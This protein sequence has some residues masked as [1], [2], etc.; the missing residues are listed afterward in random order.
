MTKCEK[1]LDQAL[2]YCQLFNL[3]APRA[4]TFETYGNLYRERGDAARAT[5]FYERA[6]RAYDEAGID[7]TR[8][9]LLDEQ[10]LLNLQLGNLTMA[11]SLL[12]RLVDARLEAKDE[13]GSH[14]AMLSR[15]RVMLAQ[16]DYEAARADLQ[17]ALEYFRE[18]GL[19]YYEAQASVALAA[20]DFV[21]GE[22]SSNLSHLRRT[23]DLA[24]RYDYEY[25]LQRQVADNPPL[26]AQAEVVELLPPDVREQL[27]SGAGRLEQRVSIIAE[28]APVTMP[29]PQHV[30]DL[31]LNMLGPVEIFRDPARPMAADAWTTKRAR[32]IL[33]FIA[34]RRHRRA[35]KDTII[36]T[37]WG[38][39]DFEAVEKNF[40]PTV[41]HIRKALNS[42]QS[43]K[44]NFL[45]YRDGDYLLNPEFSYRIDTEEFDRLVTEGETARRAREFERCI[46]AYEGAV[47]L[48]RGDF[49]QGSYDDWVEEQRSYYREQH[50]RMLEALAAVA[51]KM[52][53]WQRSLHLAQQIL[54]VDPYREDIHC[55]IMRAHA[56][57][58]NRV[59]V[60]EQYENLSRLL[61]KELGVDPAADTRKVYQELVH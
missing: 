17:P 6:A 48:Y 30:T 61:R 34:S 44:Q 58:G 20:C 9:E 57:L 40:H 2:E 29:A 23:L 39:A 25:W 51:Q 35:S 5:E 53:E 60:K 24:A 52:Q 42:N 36:D 7:L 38:E 10:A 54:H 55:M 26:F 4:E 13:R 47:A 33:C 16:T 50:L 43:L 27:Q 45:L 19:Y 8:C 15:G 59:A 1:H 22:E 18:H 11:R 21:T 3:V 12:T 28:R 32:D 14:T 31:T 37:F 41:S 49:M 46:E 56:A